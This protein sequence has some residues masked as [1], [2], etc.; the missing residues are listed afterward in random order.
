[1]KNSQCSF[2][3]SNSG[4]LWA[5]HTASTSSVSSTEENLF[6]RADRISRE[7]GPTPASPF[8]EK[9]SLTTN[10]LAGCSRVVRC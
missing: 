5:P 6:L 10:Q 3:Q 9:G 2:R 4:A 8:S 7:L 1:M